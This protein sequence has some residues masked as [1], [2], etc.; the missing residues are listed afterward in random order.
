MT[1][2]RGDRLVVTIGVFRLTKAV[3][4]AALALIA[5]SGHVAALASGIEGAIAWLGFFPGHDALLRGTDRLWSLDRHDVRLLG[6]LSGAYGAVFLVEGV[7]L[8]L[9]RRWAE[10]LTVVVTGSFIPLEVYELVRHPGA[11]KIVALVLNVAIVAYLIWR[12]L[13]SKSR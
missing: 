12:R 6:A 10:W 7:G 2:R 5:F 1:A 13:Q 8:L 11:G 3:T 4:L 9:R